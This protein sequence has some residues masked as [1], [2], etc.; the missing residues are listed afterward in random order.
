MFFKK[1]DMK[2]AHPC[3]YV[4]V[5]MIAALG[6]VACTK[7]GRQFIKSKIKCVENKLENCGALSS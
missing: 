5:G 2:C 1:P 6:A 7:P 3:L 4:A